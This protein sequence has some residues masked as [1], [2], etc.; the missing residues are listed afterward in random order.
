MLLEEK[1]RV[2]ENRVLRRMFGR[3]GKKGMGEW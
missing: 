3:T 1:N 2:F